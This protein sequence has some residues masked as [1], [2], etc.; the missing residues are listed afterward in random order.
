MTIQYNT[1]VLLDLTEQEAACLKDLLQ[2]MEA[3]AQA[4]GAAWERMR[5][6]LLFALSDRK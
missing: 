2:D 3:A 5:M 6:D 1:H 4:R